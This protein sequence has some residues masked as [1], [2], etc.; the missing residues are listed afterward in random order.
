MAVPR[1]IQECSDYLFPRGASAARLESFA[2]PE[3]AFSLLAGAAAAAVGRKGGC[4]AVLPTNLEAEQAALEA[5]FFLGSENVV[6]LPGIEAIP[7][8]YSPVPTDIASARVYALSRIARG[9]LALVCTSAVGFLR[10]LPAREDFLASGFV[11][12]TGQQVAVDAMAV[13]LHQIGYSRTEIVEAPGQFAWKAGILDIFPP[14]D[15]EPVRVEFFDDE[16]ESMRRFDSDTQRTT[17]S[18]LI[19]VEVQPASE[20][21]LFGDR[22]RRLQETLQ[23]MAAESG[24]AVPEWV[25]D[26]AEAPR[27]L[28]H[29]HGLEDVFAL[30]ERAVC[31][32]DW[33]GETWQ[34]LFFPKQTL[35]ERLAAVQREFSTLYEQQHVARVV[36][37][38]A[39]LLSSFPEG[40]GLGV[41][42]DTVPAVTAD[43]GAPL[44][45]PVLPADRFRGR[46]REVRAIV[47]ERVRAGGR[48]VIASP[49]EAQVNRIAGIFHGEEGIPLASHPTAEAVPADLAA[50]PGTLSI[51][52]AP[53]RGGFQLP[54]LDLYFWSDSDLFG[55][56]YRRKTARFKSF[57]SRP[58]DSFVDLKV[59]DFVVHV[60]HGVGR[61]VRLERVR[62]AG[63]ERDFLVLEYAD[64]DRLFVPLDQISLVQRYVSATESPRLDHLG[65]SSFRRIKERVEKRVEQLA[66]ELIEIYAVRMSRTGFAFPP[67]TMWQEEFEADFQ[68]EETP[69][70]LAA[71]EAVKRDMEA[72]RPMDRLICGDVGYG[73]TE[74]AIRAAFKAVMA[75]RQ[76]VLIAPTTILALQH[77]RTFT[78]RFAE[79][80]VRVDW[81]SRFRTTGEVA[82]AKRAAAS[83]ETDILI[84]THALIAPD[85]KFKNLG[86]LIVDE[87]QRFGVGHKEAIKNLRKLVD[88]VTLSATPIPRTLHMSLVGIRDLSI[89]QTPPR[90]RLPVR[91]YV[92]ED[93]DSILKE[94]IQ[95]ELERDGQVFY[96]HNRIETIEPAAR[97]VAN[98]VPRAG[99][100]ILHGQM[101]E[102]EIEDTLL[103]FIERR[104]DV[105]V[106]TSI[107]ESGIDMPNVNTLLVDR[108]DTFGLSQLYQIR[109]RVGRS[110]RQ[111]YAYLFHPTG[112]ALTETAQRRLNTI[113]E[114]QELGS[115]FK[116]A[117]RDLEIRGAGNILG[118]E[119][120][121]DIM[122][123][124][125]E[126]YVRL[127]DNA[128]RRL[129]GKPVPDELRCYLGLNRDFYLPEDYIP[130]SR[131]RIEFYKR[132]EG[133]ISPAEVESLAS[134]MAD[135]FGP[136]PIRA[137]EFV[138]MESIRTLASLVGLEAVSE[139]GDTIRLKAGEALRVPASHLVR[140]VQERKDLRL[141]PGASPA[142]IFSPTEPPQLV[143]IVSVLRALAAPVLPDDEAA[144]EPV[145]SAAAGHAP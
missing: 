135:R 23:R 108:A 100:R 83:G 41:W 31:I 112:R 61:F 36:A 59:G 84:G 91:T 62:A 45:G 32:R 79:Y 26:A 15:P 67:D 121:G 39:L 52:C 90:D 106:T 134:E 133:A 125:F 17:V 94:A 20:I 69:D 24:V 43:G 51:V 12:K 75:G 7:Y 141:V 27:T 21:V 16:V 37:E 9:G 101:S 98:L 35:R 64:D 99:V 107:I 73:K 118:K 56:S 63:R 89:I 1:L 29:N 122:D 111:A 143:D 140:L 13:R 42:W 4:L 130:D 97:R 57:E 22:Q 82:A 103:D 68:Y 76:V 65:R 47:A 40:D 86:L 123:V 10:K 33:F 105:L 38:P 110:D 109:G 144:P 145:G 124:G 46:I 126:L 136:P 74:V 2:L 139:D 30:T 25:E 60:N 96:L 66:E 54:A 18:G 115:G 71:I 127:L 58:L 142:L 3:S 93:S 116:V 50:R 14:G 49:Y 120:S 138:Q 92:M 85:V 44:P 81:I 5:A 48:I 34:T 137:V 117:M 102:E 55:R 131:Q 80:P 19:E 114:Y 132:F 119:Q 8:E 28:Q 128:V 104:Y 53:L 78:Q 6:F 11:L 70:Q 72:P 88:V 113:H 95:R 77:F 87:E 129:Q